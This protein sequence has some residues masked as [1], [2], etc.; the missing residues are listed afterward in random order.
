MKYGKQVKESDIIHFACDDVEVFLMLV[1]K[2]MYVYIWISAFQRNVQ[3]RVEIY[4]PKTSP[5]LP[6]LIG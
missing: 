3:T 4:S 1:R 2:F 6:A 5:W